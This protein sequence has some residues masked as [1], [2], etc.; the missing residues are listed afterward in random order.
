[1]TYKYGTTMILTGNKNKIKKTLDF[2]FHIVIL[3]AREKF[4]LKLK[5]PKEEIRRKPKRV[6][7]FSFDWALKWMKTGDILYTRNEDKDVTSRT[8]ALWLNGQFKTERVVLV[9]MK[10]GETEKGVLITKL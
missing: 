2:L 3:M 9:H 8:S 7:Q 4:T 1:M 5:T 10:S 6:Y